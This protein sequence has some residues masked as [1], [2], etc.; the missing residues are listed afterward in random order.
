MQ[1][2]TW[3]TQTAPGAP[4]DHGIRRLLR[5]VRR[6][7]ELQD[8]D[9]VHLL[10][11]GRLGGKRQACTHAAPVLGHRLGGIAHVRAEVERVVRRRR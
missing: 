10:E 3:M 11:P 2:A 8:A 9:A 6:S 7:I 5:R 4:G 1:S